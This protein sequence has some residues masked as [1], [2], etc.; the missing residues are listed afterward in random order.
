ML[1]L[2]PNSTGA[3]GAFD[4][5]ER[6]ALHDSQDRQQGVRKPDPAFTYDYMIQDPEQ[7]EA[8]ELC[9]LLDSRHHQQGVRKQDPAL[10]SDYMLQ[11]PDALDAAELLTGSDL[12]PDYMGLLLFQD[13]LTVGTAPS[14]WLRGWQA[15]MEVL[16]T[17]FDE[18]RAVD[19]AFGMVVARC[20][21]RRDQRYMEWIRRPVGALA[22]GIPNFGWEPVNVNTPATFYHWSF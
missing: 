18:G 6:C 22:A 21:A 1:T 5:G 3:L 7:G 20:Q 16:G 14:Q 9:V 15:L 11:D 8:G 19:M 12:A 17:W 4:I 2:A 10:F 13:V